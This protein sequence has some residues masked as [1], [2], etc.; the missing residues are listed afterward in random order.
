MSFNILIRFIQKPSEEPSHYVSDMAERNGRSQ[1]PNQ[2]RPSLVAVTPESSTR[3]SWMQFPATVSVPEPPRPFY[4]PFDK[5]P[6][7]Q[8]PVGD[9]GTYSS[10]TT[11]AD[12]NLLLPSMAS[13]LAAAT[14]TGFDGTLDPGQLFTLGSMVDDGFFGYGLFPLVGDDAGNGNSYLG[15]W[16]C[17]GAVG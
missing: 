14:S 11:A 7:Q 5:Q 15:G 8:Q 12:G 17:L 10:T 13:P 3:Q 2:Y 16:Q 9:A 4:A 1:P 6:P